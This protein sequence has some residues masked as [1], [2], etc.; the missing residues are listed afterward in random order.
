MVSLISTL[1]ADTVRPPILGSTPVPPARPLRDRATQL[2]G[3]ALKWSSGVEMLT[4]PAGDII[5]S[6]TGGRVIAQ[7]MRPLGETGTRQTGRA[8]KHGAEEA[9]TSQGD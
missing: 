5:P 7:P 1:V 2:F 4:I 6:R 9:S 3:R 8:K